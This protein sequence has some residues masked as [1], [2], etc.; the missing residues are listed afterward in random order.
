[1]V[2][3]AAESMIHELVELVRGKLITDQKPV[4]KPLEDWRILTATN[5]LTD[6]FDATIDK[7]K[8]RALRERYDANWRGFA[9]QLRTTRNDAGHPTSVEPVT[10]D[11]VHAS[12]LIFPEFA[13]LATAL[14]DWVCDEM[15]DSRSLS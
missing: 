2:G 12:L 10:E 5:A 11:M 9:G 4:P 6:I 8:H 13:G 1:M 7:K 3:A 15:P 14:F